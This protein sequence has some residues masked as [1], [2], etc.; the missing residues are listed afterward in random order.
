MLPVMTAQRSKTVPTCSRGRR[1]PEVKFPIR[2]KI[3]V[4]AV[5]PTAAWPTPPME[6][7]APV[8]TG[9]MAERKAESLVRCVPVRRNNPDNPPTMQKHPESRTQR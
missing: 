7:E 5:P 8:T 6:R 9:S 2:E 1:I 4:K 3:M